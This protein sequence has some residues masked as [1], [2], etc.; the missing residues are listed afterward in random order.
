MGN[1][2]FVIDGATF[3]VEVHSRSEGA[4]EVTVNGRRMR[5]EH[6]PLARATGSDRRSAAVPRAA[7]RTVVA[8]AGELRAPM[9]GRVLLVV[10]AVG[11]AVVRGAPLVVLDAMKMENSLGS[12]RDG[13]VEEVVV[14]PG[15]TVL[16][17]ALLVRVRG[18]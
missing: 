14:R 4:A 1:H 12:P 16:Q 13:V 10:A 11:T 3:D 8:A 6:M 7:A 17:G 18:A 5:V 9:A 15:D 2:R